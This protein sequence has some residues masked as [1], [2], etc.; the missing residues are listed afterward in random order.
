M[1]MTNALIHVYTPFYCWWHDKSFV[2]CPSYIGSRYYQFRDLPKS[3]NIL[4]VVWNY[5]WHPQ[6]LGNVISTTTFILLIKPWINVHETTRLHGCFK[7]LN[8]ANICCDY[9]NKCFEP[10]IFFKNKVWIEMKHLY[11]SWDFSK[12]MINKLWSICSTTSPSMCVLVLH[13]LLLLYGIV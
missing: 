5:T 11:I 3:F 9:G 13:V 1:R 12:T 2:S 8:F 6:Q 7:K 4:S 10:Q